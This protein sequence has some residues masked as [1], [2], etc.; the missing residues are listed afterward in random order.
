[1]R[2]VD[3]GKRN[4]ARRGADGRS[5]Q[6]KTTLLRRF[7][8]RLLQGPRRLEEAVSPVS[9]I[10]GKLFDSGWKRAT[11]QLGSLSPLD[12]LTAATHPGPLA[13]G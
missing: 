13:T 5:F 9:R 4:V 12:Y 6:A 8:L 3:F 1:V 11:S 7:K 2:R 10:R